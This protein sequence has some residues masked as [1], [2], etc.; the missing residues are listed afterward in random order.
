MNKYNISTPTTSGIKDDLKDII[1]NNP[2]EIA[3]I[4][5]GIFSESIK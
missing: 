2:F 1:E 3:V 5:S 4:I